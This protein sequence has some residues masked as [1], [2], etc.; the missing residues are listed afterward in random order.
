MEYAALFL[1]TKK[2]KTKTGQ[3]GSSFDRLHARARGW[4]TTP[5]LAVRAY[6]RQRLRIVCVNPT[7]QAIKRV[8]QWQTGSS[9]HQR[10]A[11]VARLD[12]LGNELGSAGRAWTFDRW[13]NKPTTI[14]VAAGLR[15]RSVPTERMHA[16]VFVVRWIS[17]YDHLAGLRGEPRLYVYIWVV[18]NSPI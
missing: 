12:C 8:A 1:I 6:V 14:R 9:W 10:S 13:S 16:R 2:R 7:A 3:F 15:L 4:P 11:Q 18:S 5:S 17:P